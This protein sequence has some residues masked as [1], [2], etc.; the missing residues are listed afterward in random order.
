MENSNDGY[1]LNNYDDDDAS[2][3]SLEVNWK[4][5]PREF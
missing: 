1:N 3:S 4:C 2:F 5:F